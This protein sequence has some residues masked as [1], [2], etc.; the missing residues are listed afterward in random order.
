MPNPAPEWISDRAWTNILTIP[1]L[2]AF[3]TF[4]EEFPQNVQGFKRM[5]DSQE[6]HRYSRVVGMGV[7]CG[8][9]CGVD[10]SMGVE[11]GV[12]GSVGVEYGGGV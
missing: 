5:F 6:P 8:V 4:A 11:C 9:E 10:G 1:S 7:E 3:K 12:H 2:P